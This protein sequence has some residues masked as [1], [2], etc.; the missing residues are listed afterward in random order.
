M[1]SDQQ[2]EILT[3]LTLQSQ[4][5]RIFIK[6]A[7]NLDLCGL[8]ECN[9]FEASSSAKNHL[10]YIELQELQISKKQKQLILLIT[11]GSSLTIR[12]TKSFF[13]DAF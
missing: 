2:L 7:Q 3:V 1:Q 8:S 12:N 13:V 5:S 11:P 9:L 10:F 4:S 6:I